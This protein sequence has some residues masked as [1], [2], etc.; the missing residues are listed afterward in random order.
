M[1]GLVRTG[2]TIPR[3]PH[4]NRP[5]RPAFDEFRLAEGLAAVLL[6]ARDRVNPLDD[7]ADARADVTM[8]MG[9]GRLA[10]GECG[11]GI[12][13]DQG[14]VLRC[15]DATAGE[16]ILGRGVE[17]GGLDDQRGGRTMAEEQIKHPV[18]PL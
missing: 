6:A 17:H 18:K 9:N 5:D 12:R 4:W 2:A 7:A 13:A 16:V 11:I 10:P 14:N 15:H 3:Y 1:A 8:N